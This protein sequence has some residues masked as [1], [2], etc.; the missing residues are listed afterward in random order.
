VPATLW[1]LAVRDWR[2]YGV[3]LLWYPIII[4]WEGENISVPLM[5]LVA[6]AWRHRERPLV[7][8][9]LTAA[10]ISMK[11][12]LWPL[13]LWLLATRRWRAAACALAAGLVFNLL[14]W[15]IVG[16]NEISAYVH[17]SQ[18]DARALW[19]GGYGVL[20]L[21]HHLGLGRGAGYVLLALA[22]A[23]LA[24][25]VLRRGLRGDD[26]QAFVLAIALMLVASPLVWIHYFVLLLVPIAIARPRFSGLWV[27]PVAMWLLPPATR[28][29]DW[30]FALAWLLVA[31]CLAAALRDGPVGRRLA[32]HRPQGKRPTSL[33]AGG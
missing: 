10:A 12:F 24:A 20:A 21:A 18:E 32:E 6:L 13:G 8:G 2:A 25:I 17:M 31:G 9:A 26:R 1:V 11:P 7:A 15:A 33:A 30:Q 28:V 29:N 27:V 5:F 14:A 19:Q 23:A 3:T 22:S 16:F 4:G